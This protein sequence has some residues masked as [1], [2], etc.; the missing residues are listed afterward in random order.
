MRT[1]RTGEAENLNFLNISVCQ[2]LNKA[3]PARFASHFS[4]KLPFEIT[5][6]DRVLFA[7]YYKHDKAAPPEQRAR[8]HAEV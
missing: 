8:S 2:V 4:K 1:S 5:P 3:K 7:K 6:D